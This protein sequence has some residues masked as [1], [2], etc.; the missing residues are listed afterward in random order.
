MVE[1]F[2]P[3]LRSGVSQRHAIGNSCSTRAGSSA[4]VLQTGRRP[5][6]SEW[7]GNAATS[8][9]FES[10]S[11]AFLQARTTG[12]DRVV[13]P[14]LLDH[15]EPDVLCTTTRTTPRTEPSARRLLET[16]PGCNAKQ[17]KRPM[18]G[19]SR[20]LLFHAVAAAAA[21]DSAGPSAHRRPAPG[22]AVVGGGGAQARQR[23]PAAL[24]RHTA[25]LG[26]RRRSRA[27]CEQK[28]RRP[29]RREM[30]EWRS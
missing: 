20:V 6:P 18:H 14:D 28:R 26:E 21:A 27:N 15:V 29:E 22:G 3:K 1:E 17:K 8:F 9:F 12:P 13:D 30:R 25:R 2:A 19:V 5:P 24:R 4:S 11:E 7:R 23:D 10:V 16:E